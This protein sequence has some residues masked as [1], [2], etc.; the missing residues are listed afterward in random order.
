[1]RKLKP[2]EARSISTIAWNLFAQ[3]T[4]SLHHFSSQ[5]FRLHLSNRADLVLLAVKVPAGGQFRATAASGPADQAFS[6]QQ[7]AAGV[8]QRDRELLTGTGDAG[9]SWVTEVGV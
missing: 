8:R 3:G 9:D 6:L 2:R 7:D 5:C 4:S 1:M